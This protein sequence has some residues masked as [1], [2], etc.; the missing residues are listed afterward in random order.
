MNGAQPNFHQLNSAAAFSVLRSVYEISNFPPRAAACNATRHEELTCC[1]YTY[2]DVHTCIRINWLSKVRARD[3]LNFNTVCLSWTVKLWS[4]LWSVGGARKTGRR[5]K[6]SETLHALYRNYKPVFRG[7][8]WVAVG[9]SVSRLDGR[10]VSIHKS[11]KNVIQ[12]R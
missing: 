6:K 8:L 7:I 2:V 10:T 5:W 3:S 9:Q 11:V 1:T 12:V 4:V